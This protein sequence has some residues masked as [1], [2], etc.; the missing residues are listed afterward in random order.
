MADQHLG[1]RGCVRS[2]LTRDIEAIRLSTYSYWIELGDYC[3]W[4][5]PTDPRFDP[6]CYPE[7]SHISDLS[8]LSAYLSRMVI[9]TFKPIRHKCLGF[10]LGNHE[11][12]YMN[13]RNEMQ[14]H[15]S[16]CHAMKV[17]N[18][19]YSGWVDLY[20]VYEQGFRGS[21]VAVSTVI[22][23][24]FTARLRVFVHHGAGAA[25]TAGGKVNRLKGFVDMS[26]SADLICMGHLHEQFSKQFTRLTPNADC[27]EIE[28]KVA[29][30]MITGSYLKNYAPGYISYGERAGYQP[31]SLGATK[32]MYAPA[33]RR[34]VVEN[35]ADG[36]G[37]KGNT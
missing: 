19:G 20:F 12:Q 11:Y 5:S 17:P 2:H 14:V 23:K 25:A 36:V 1:N 7:D 15:G 18:M 22:P 33:I 3:D 21:K 26:A 28:S 27:S 8:E 10:G 35:S 37:L 34:L 29:M 31:T 16:I 24:K 4:I 32:A 9:E 6:Q 30:G 13:R